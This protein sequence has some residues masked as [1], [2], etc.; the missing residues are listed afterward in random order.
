MVQFQTIQKLCCVSRLEDR[1]EPRVGATCPVRLTT[2]SSSMA[3]TVVSTTGGYLFRIHLLVTKMNVTD[4]LLDD[5][6]FSDFRRIL[7]ILAKLLF[8]STYF[9]NLPHDLERVQ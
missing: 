5:F 3:R 4:G 1:A 7:V 6:M 8:I 9:L 2:T